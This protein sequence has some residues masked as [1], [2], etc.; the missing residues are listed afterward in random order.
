MSRKTLNA[1]K[2]LNMTRKSFVWGMVVMAYKKLYPKSIF[3]VLTDKMQIKIYD[4]T[5]GIEKY[6]G[7]KL[8]ERS[9]EN[10]SLTMLLG[11]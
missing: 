5:R 9:I 4:E 6:I 1:I 7:R 8:I 2:D 11:R 3:K 10:N